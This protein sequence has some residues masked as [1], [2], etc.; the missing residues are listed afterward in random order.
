M[1]SRNYPFKILSIGTLVAL[2]GPFQGLTPCKEASQWLQSYFLGFSM[3]N[4]LCSNYFLSLLITMLKLSCRMFGHSE[5]STSLSILTCH[6]YFLDCLPATGMVCLTVLTCLC[7][8]QFVLDLIVSG[9]TNL[10]TMRPSHTSTILLPYHAPNFAT[11]FAQELACTQARLISY[12]TAQNGHFT[13]GHSCL[14]PI[15]SAGELT[16]T[17]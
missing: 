16:S 3:E 11:L 17:I 4:I 6:D 15:H 7:K 13:P 14:T 8:I 2:L 12:A 9:I 5:P 1:R 10:R